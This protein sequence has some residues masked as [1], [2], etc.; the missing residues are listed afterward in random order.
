MDKTLILDYSGESFI[1]TPKNGI[2]VPWN[3]SVRD[4]TLVDLIQI[5]SF[6]VSNGS[7]VELSLEEYRK[8]VNLLNTKSK[9]AFNTLKKK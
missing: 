2:E 4:K 1:T 5:I 3:R 8:E 6:I 7:P 9:S